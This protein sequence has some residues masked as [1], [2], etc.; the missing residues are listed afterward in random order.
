VGL[1]CRRI[2]ATSAAVCWIIV[3]ALS[4][5]GAIAGWG[6]TSNTGRCFAVL[7]SAAVVLTITAVI[8]YA[9]TPMAVSQGIGYRAAMRAARDGAS[10]SRPP[11]RHAKDADS[12]ARVIQFQLRRLIAAVPRSA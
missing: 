11:G 9:I 2:L 7:L 5:A 8:G 4:A 12:G 1:R 10:Q 3:I 6:Y